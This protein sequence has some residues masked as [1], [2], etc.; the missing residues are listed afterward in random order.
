MNDHDA[1]PT[2]PWTSLP[3]LISGG[4]AIASLV[5]S[6]SRG[7]S[8]QQ[9]LSR[10]ESRIHE[11]YIKPHDRLLDAHETK[12]ERIG[13]LGDENAQ[14][15]RYQEQQIQEMRAQIRE[16]YQALGWRQPPAGEK[17]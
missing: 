12:L 13:R 8:T 1:R 14:W 6:L 11:Y 16:L 2:N 3:A 9:D 4:I 17:K 15:N 5:F 10:Q 7:I